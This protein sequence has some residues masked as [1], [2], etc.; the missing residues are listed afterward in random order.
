M[1]GNAVGMGFLLQI[2]ILHIHSH[3]PT[4]KRVSYIGAQVK[5]DK[6]TSGKAG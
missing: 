2:N 3:L 6:K 5:G 1:S 4:K